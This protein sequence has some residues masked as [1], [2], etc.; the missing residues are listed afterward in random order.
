MHSRVIPFASFTVLVLVLF[1]AP[2][3]FAAGDIISR[4]NGLVSF[5]S[6]SVGPIIIG[7]GLIGG[8]AA[9]ALGIPGAVQK[10]LSVVVGGILLTSVGSVLSF[11]QVL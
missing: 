6:E 3:A 5:L 8:A 1:W 11:I 4:G 10:L 7:L 2:D 9:L